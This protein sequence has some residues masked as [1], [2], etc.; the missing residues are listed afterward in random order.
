VNGNGAVRNASQL[1]LD[2][3][4]LSPRGAVD[5]VI[6]PYLD[7]VE[8]DGEISVVCLDGQPSHAVWKKPALG[9]FR[10]HEHR[11]GTAEPIPLRR[12]HADLARR[13]LARLPMVPAIAR[14]DLLSHEDRAYVVELE[15]VE[16]YLWLELAPGSADRLADSLV[17]RA[18]ATG[19]I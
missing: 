5:V 2:T 11:G 3:L 9:E 4:T 12:D 13:V 6:Q 14:V 7:S 19:G 1:D 16:P 18:L 17:H 8:R 10:I 15:L